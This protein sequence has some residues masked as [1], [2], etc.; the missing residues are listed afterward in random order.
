MKTRIPTLFVALCLSLLVAVSA[1]AQ[2]VRTYTITLTNLTP[3]QIIGPPVL[4]THSA[5]TSVFT[6]GEPASAGVAALAEDADASVLLEDLGNDSQVFD[7]AM[8]SGPLMP[9]A[10]MEIEI[11]AAAGYL[12]LSAL[13]MLVT[14][15]DA[16]FGAST[17]TLPNGRRMESFTVPAYDSGSEANTESCDDIP[18]PP[19]GNPFQR[20]TDGAEGFV[21][22]HRG[23]HGVGDLTSFGYDW[24]NPVVRISVRRN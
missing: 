7:V 6:S 23:M 19:C 4:V 11:D 14:T 22:I 17:R 12:R 21:H 1:Q 16:F 3:T 20:V 24:R 5:R 9:G 8:A 10:S 2:P 18:G 13:G 15:N